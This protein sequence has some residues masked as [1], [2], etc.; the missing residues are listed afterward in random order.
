MEPSD[1]RSPAG[2]VGAP[3]GQAPTRPHRERPTVRQLEY[4]VALGDSLHFRRA[5]EAVS[6][7]QPALSAQ[8]QAL[9][10]L[11]GIQLFERTRRK[12]LLTRA[13]REAVRRARIL[14]EQIDD[15]SDATRAALQPLSGELRLG[16]I[17]TLAPYVLPRTLP[18]IRERFPDLKLYLREEFTQRLLER[19]HQGE[20]DLLLLAL[21]GGGAELDH[22]LLFRDPFLLAMPKNHPLASQ[23]TIAQSDLDGLELLL[24]ED[25]HCLRDQALAVCA[26]RGAREDQRFRA[27]SLGTLIQMVSNGLGLT[28]L[29]EVAATIEARSGEGVVLRAFEEPQPCRDVG[30]VWRK[31]SPRAEEYRLLGEELMRLLDEQPQGQ[32]SLLGR[33]TPLKPQPASVR[34]KSGEQ[35][36]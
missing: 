9:E 4:L 34:S 6:I 36:K 2:R 26:K 30:L 7:S 28:L 11:W 16:I 32:P 3:A 1:S 33:L 20:L 23:K 19:L 5:A 14:L 31:S 18:R 17:P 24:L 12:V 10:E 29:P 27:S 15:L 8:V 22:L 25:G 21:P 35:G 13:G